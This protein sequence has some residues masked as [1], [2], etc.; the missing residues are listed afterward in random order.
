MTARGN[1]PG[2][3]IKQPEPCKGSLKNKIE[4]AQSL[5][6]VLLHLIYST[7]NREKY[8]VD[9]NL[10]NELYAYTSSALKSLGCNCI[11]ADGTADHIHIFFVMLRTESISNV[12]KHIKKETSKWIKTKSLDYSSLLSKFAW[13][14]GYGIFSVSASQK[15]KVI[16]YI[17]GQKDHHKKITFK[18]ELLTFLKKYEIGYDEKYLWD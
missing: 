14:S 15:E 11:I 13:Q 1:A 3:N 16:S 9:T 7:K 8:L 12:V 18:E 5:S 4:M 2:K 6:N 17:K 10:Q